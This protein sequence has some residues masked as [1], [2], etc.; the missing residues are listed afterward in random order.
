VNRRPFAERL[1]DALCTVG[2]TSAAFYFALHILA[3]W[4]RGSFEVIR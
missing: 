2:V 3:A 1:A 4:L